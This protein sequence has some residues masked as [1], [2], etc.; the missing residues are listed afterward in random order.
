M[1]RLF[2][3]LLTLSTLFFSCKEASDPIGPEQDSVVLKTPNGGES[4]EVGKPFNIT[5]TSTYTSN[6][7]I[8]YSTN[9]GAS[10]LM[11]VPSTPNTGEYLWRSVP[12]TRSSL[13]K[14]RLTTL[15]TLRVVDESNG[16]FSIIESR[17]KTL[18]LVS[19][20]G[21]EVLIVGRS[22]KIKWNHTGVSNIRIEYSTN[23]G[24]SWGD[25]VPS[26]PA[27]SLEYTWNPIPNT[28][29]TS[30]RVRISDTVADTLKD[31]SDAVF[32]I[33][34]AKEIQV[35]K[36]NGGENLIGMGFEEITWN[37][38]QV[39]NVKIEY[40]TNNGLTW[41][42]I[43][44][45]IPSNGYYIWRPIPNTPSANAKIKITNAAESFPTDESDGV[46]TI[47]PELNLIIETPNGGES[48]LSGS[49]QIIK[50]AAELSGP[51]GAN[52]NF[53]GDEISI[54]NKSVTT[55][56][57]IRK[58][59][60]EYT[61]NNG[62]N[63]ITITDST[64]N[65]GRFLWQNLPSANSA[66][67]KVRI[68][69]A[70]DGLPFDESD[71][72]FTIY[73]TLAQEITVV[74]PNGSEEFP[75]GTSQEI[76]WNSS[77]IASVKIEYTT[78]NGVSWILLDANTPSDGFYIW[79][80]IPSTSSNNCKVRISDASDNFPFD[81]SNGTFS[82]VS[83]PEI[84][85]VSPNG[86]EL[87]QAGSTQNVTWTS[88]N[89]ANVRIEFSSNGGASWSTIISST[90][91]DGAY[92]WLVPNL[93]SLLCRIRISD[94]SDGA[95]FDI[96][97]NNFSISNQV[98]QEVEL[99]S[100]NGGETFEGGTTQRISWFSNGINKV[101][102]EYSTN[103]GASWFLIKD[104]TD[105]DGSFDW[106]P[107]P[108]ISSTMCKVRISDF[109][110]GSPSDISNST[111]EITQTKTLQVVSPNGG[112]TWTAGELNKILWQ[113]SGV[114]SVRI[115]YSVDNGRFWQPV[116]A[117]TPSD[118][119][120]DWSPTIVSRLYKI[121]IINTDVSGVPADESDGT[122]TVNEEPLVRIIAPNGGE[123][124]V[125]G[126][127]QNIN[128]YSS[129][130]SNVK[131]EFTSNN[132]ATWNLIVNSTESDGNYEWIVPNFTSSLS[133]VRISDALDNKP[134]DVSDS[135]FLIFQQ[136]QFGVTVAS[137]NG[138]EIWNAGTQQFITWSSTGVQNVKIDYTTNNGVSWLEVVANTPSDGLYEWT[139]VPNTPSSNARVRITDVINNYQDIS[140]SIFTIASEPFVLVLSP[141]GGETWFT[142][143]GPQFIR[144]QSANVRDVKIQ[145]STNGGAAW[146]TI[147]NSTPS[148]GFFN[149]ENIPANINSKLCLIRIADAV[150]ESPS[151]VSDNYFEMTSAK[152]IQVTFP[153]DGEYIFQDTIIT[154]QAFGVNDVRLEYTDNNGLTWNVI[155]A[156]VRNTG[157]YN[158]F[159][160][161]TQPSTLAK[162]RVSDV[163]APAISD[164]SD[165]VFNLHIRQG[166]VVII[167]GEIL[168]GKS[169]QTIEW[170]SEEDESK[171]ALEYSLD[172]G[173]TWVLISD[174]V[175][176]Q[177]NIIN[178]FDWKLP[179]NLNT[180][181]LKVRIK[182]VGN[183]FISD[184]KELKIT[185]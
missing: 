68:S 112:E 63:W 155:A 26:I 138:G 23:N 106:G 86:S 38:S 76:K 182:D 137:P 12:N 113:S 160:P 54:D 132:G 66:L 103:N 167:S 47:A 128:W 24:Q 153:N 6:L 135:T 42:T 136:N 74:E 100:P 176:N 44:S 82:I 140:D 145:Y 22:Q 55:A 64:D 185:E 95:P 141:N 48:W 117:S 139:F 61:T 83:E 107:L 170:T 78:N 108:N 172:E 143:S 148:N 175:I 156:S 131:I 19:P 72:F 124:W 67:C 111:F 80:Q 159:L 50:W 9:N 56:G 40:T 88:T 59:K 157:A 122:F 31:S 25:I 104:S 81:E 115:E 180:Q 70:N 146:N 43:A 114:A 87:I 162:I 110:D 93:N 75:A 130:L 29:S 123:S 20:N 120:F 41:V 166:R 98:V 13:C 14:V 163:T 102:L 27:D 57:T 174:G 71:A 116:I 129:N 92:Q 11:I 49:T 62:A 134:S 151:D 65:N 127:R 15:D 51:T 53:V 125:S 1:K 39:E 178:R 10:W 150:D 173:R 164:I 154:W 118:G 35:I 177:K 101:R 37:S 105:S 119:E 144:W 28:P 171:V 99:T 183:K 158:W 121:R 109:T 84:T 133:R 16:L 85:V 8:E 179:E 52:T 96:S 60:L 169:I 184:D 90:E 149:W 46:F 152:F 30:A 45:S 161:P 89:I 5:W 58:V 97:D 4:L 7:K 181:S 147:T 21:G 33:S 17:T 91:S 2:F 168:A 3:Y 142:N 165:K 126:S 34:V 18:S 73:N 77:G 69:D 94:A 36:P 32:T 79:S